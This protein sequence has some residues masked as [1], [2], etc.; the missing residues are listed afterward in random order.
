MVPL[1]KQTLHTLLHRLSPRLTKDNRYISSG[2]SKFGAIT[3]EKDPLGGAK[4]TLSYQLYVDGAP[5][6]NATITSPEKSPDAKPAG[7]LW[8]RLTGAR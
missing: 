7:G 4:S 8:D 5:A 3:I 2:H 1:Q 6:W